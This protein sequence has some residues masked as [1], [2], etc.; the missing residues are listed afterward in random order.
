MILVVL[1]GSDA[2]STSNLGAMADKEPSASSFPEDTTNHAQGADEFRTAPQKAWPA[3]SSTTSIDPMSQHRMGVEADAVIRLGLML[4]NA[5]TSAYRVMRA[6]KRAARAL[7]F[8]QLDI[9]VT[10]NTITCTFHRGESFRTVV[11][12][13]HHVGVDAS[14]IEAIENLAHNFSQGYSAAELNAALDGIEQK[15]V[16]RWNRPALALSAGIACFGFALL[17]HYSLFEATA[18]L[19]AAMCGQWVRVTLHRRHLNT[20]GAVAIAAAVACLVYALIGVASAQIPQL[21]HVGTGFVAAVLFLIPGFPLYSAL[22]DLCRF[23]MQ[24]GL[25][26]L[27]YA[28]SIICAATLTV[29]MLSTIIDMPALAQAHAPLPLWAA[30]IASLLGIGGFAV[31]FNSSRRM[32]VV[33]AVAGTAA[34]IVRLLIIHQGI[35]PQYAAAAG[36]LT[37][38]LIAAWLA[39]KNGLPRITTTVPAAVIMVPGTAMYESVYYLNNGSMDQAISSAATA[40][41]MVLYITAGLAVSRMLTD[42]DWTFSHLVEMHKPLPH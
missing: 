19:L 16:H 23:D 36:G 14:R 29:S 3:E 37:V 41:L 40:G 11:A 32:V 15:V 10:V 35:S 38:G 9:V 17:N 5:G 2:Y 20:L 25:T 7:R 13:Q 22:L 18:V 33:A 26:R 24:A 30:T 8:D 28:L 6:M 12:H 4:M 31:L 42:K 21:P 27:F 34:N 1:S 39:K